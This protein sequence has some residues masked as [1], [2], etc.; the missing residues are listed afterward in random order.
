MESKLRGGFDE[1]SRRKGRGRRWWWR[2][3]RSVVSARVPPLPPPQSTSSDAINR[4]AL[5]SSL[6]R[7]RYPRSTPAHSFSAVLKLRDRPL[8]ERGSDP[9]ASRLPVPWINSL[10]IRTAL[11]CRPTDQGSIYPPTLTFRFFL[12]PQWENRA[13]TSWYV[14]PPPHAPL[15]RA[16]STHWWYLQHLEWGVLVAIFNPGNVKFGLGDP[17][18]LLNGCEICHG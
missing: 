9:K 3:R 5:A 2:R 12:R 13:T 1:G 7:A 17:N 14:W 15:E 6:S 11:P 10:L 16:V 18:F 8:S 4:T